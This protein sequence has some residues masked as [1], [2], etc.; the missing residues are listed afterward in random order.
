[1]TNQIKTSKIKLILIAETSTKSCNQIYSCNSLLLCDRPC[2]FVAPFCE[3]K[4]WSG[5]HISSLFHSC[6]N[7]F[8][9][10]LVPFG[11]KTA[12]YCEELL[13]SLAKKD[14][15]GQQETMG[16]ESLWICNCYSSYILRRPQN[17][18][19]SSPYF[20]LQYVLSKARWRFHKIGAF[21]E[22]MNFT[23]IITK[24][25][26]NLSDGHLT[27]SFCDY[28]IDVHHVDC[29]TRLEIEF[30]WRIFEG[31]AIKFCK[32]E[33]NLQY[34]LAGSSQTFVFFYISSSSRHEKLCQMA[35]RLFAVF[36]DT[37]NSTFCEMRHP[38]EFISLCI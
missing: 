37:M 14:C 13:N 35:V 12:V 19:K 25:S 32:N 18:A 31:S 9:N 7:Y 4:I 27:I 22:Y 33:P 5:K 26:Q 16:Q 17:F 2:D 20:W 11:N 29:Q 15:N 23:L 36:F 3:T 34:H 28:F 10:V 8:A 6:K 21:S 24:L 1:M 38:R 30:P